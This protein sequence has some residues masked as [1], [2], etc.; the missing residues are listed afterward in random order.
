M[1]SLWKLKAGAEN[2]YLGQVASGIEDYYTGDKEAAG[3]WA[4]QGSPLLGLAGEVDPDDLRA[5][6][7]GLAPRSEL[8]PNG[9]RP[10]PHPRRVPGFDLTFSVPKS[11]SVLYAL[12]DPLVRAEVL[13][14][15]EA[16]V[17]QGLAW[18]EREACHVRRGTNNRH[19]HVSTPDDWGTRRL[20]GKGFVAAV[21]RHR[22]SRAED[23]Q[24]HWHVLVANMTSGP[25]SRWSALDATSLY[26]TQ[27]AAG[28]IFR[29]ALRAELTE[30]LGVAWTPSTDDR[31]E[32]AGIPGSILRLFSKRRA[33]IEYE[34]DRL[35]ESGPAASA[36][37]TLATRTPKATF[38]EPGIDA[39]WHTEATLAGWGPADLD[40]LLSHLRT[41]GS[42]PTLDEIVTH[43]AHEL[44]ASDSTFTRHEIART[45][46]TFLPT[47]VT[48]TRLDQL[49]SDVL[50]HPAV[51]PIG[52]PPTPAVGWEERFTT[53]TLLALE[54]ELTDH[55]T[56]TDRVDP[57]TRH[58]IDA[59]LAAHPTLDD[60][61]KHAIASLLTATHPIGVLV[62]RAGTGK[63]F[64]LAALGDAYRTDGYR[65]IGV[66]P[67][68]RAAREL[69]TGANIA[70]HTIPRFHRA[71]G[72]D[73]LDRR[74]VVIIDEAA[75][76]NTVDLHA[77]ITRTRAAGARVLL[78]GDHHQLP[79]IGAGGGFAAAV[80]TCPNVTELT[81]NRRQHQPWE[82]EALEHLR[83]GHLPTAWTAY[84]DHGRVTITPDT[85]TAHAQA[86]DD[87][88]TTHHTGASSM[89]L[90]GTRTEATR[91]NELARRRAAD[92][93]MLT[94]PTLPVGNRQ[95][96]AG[97]RVLFCRNDT[98]QR[99]RNGAMSTVENGTLATVTAI[100]LD[101]TLTARCD[102]G[103]YVVVQRP[104]LA[105]SHLDHGYAMTVHKAQGATCD[106]VYVVGPAGLYR[107]A[108]YVAMSRARHG[109]RLY[110][111]V[112]QYDELVERDHS[113]GTPVDED[114]TAEQTLIDRLT[115][116]R[117]KQLAS[118]LDPDA[119]AIARLDHLTL[120]ELHD[121]AARLRAFEADM[122]RQG[123]EHPRIALRRYEAALRAR[124]YLA[125]GGGVRAL[126]RGNVGTVLTI[127][128]SNYCASVYFRSASG[129][130][131][132]RSLPWHALLPVGRTAPTAGIEPPLHHGLMV[133][134][135]ARQRWSQAASARGLPMIELRGIEIAL[136]R[137][138]ATTVAI[139]P[140]VQANSVTGQGADREASGLPQP[141]GQRDRVAAR[142]NEVRAA[143]GVARDIG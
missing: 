64:T 52:D 69:A 84:R 16:A 44:V 59:T 117:A 140:A 102:D 28:P 93:G 87:W 106:H 8:S 46:A 119:R 35:G 97:D 129:T 126:D 23:P 20:P 15:G 135:A 105:D 61:Q 143:R 11:V 92:A 81:I 121:L 53:R 125:V 6:L 112:A 42:E 85:P 101:A 98:R 47:G 82:I 124:Q 7:G 107:E 26:R 100:N 41:V 13:A 48:P 120:D 115:P 138:G 62:G 94:G 56:T 51:I 3:Y 1:L 49:T 133:G 122:A 21:F 32:I 54:A 27:R 130:R 141:A 99:T 39:R 34:L 72:Q 43:V 57:L 45:I 30:R 128:D 10:R 116:S 79:E 14:A 60:D 86:I 95:F 71:I 91:L 58:T 113:T 37:A 109:A 127:D 114:R 19:A 132:I 134:D 68:A 77:L 65:V 139:D 108:A 123:I 88:W 36:R 76:S 70:A 40:R 66:A 5:V 18:L 12:G 75:M 9:D 22:V 31:S 17:A 73:P 67:S 63:T 118:V 96:Q 110:A 25:D 24:L 136:L 4:G 2:Y 50:A 89:L 55:L 38:D 103:R 90:A 33:D 104:Y 142:C 74:S 131:R 137:A 111:T 83:H 80:D 78:V 29:A